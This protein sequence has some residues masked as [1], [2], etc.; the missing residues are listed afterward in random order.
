MNFGQAC[1][2]LKRSWRAYK[3][4]GRDGAGTRADLAWRINR[5]QS[6]MGLKSNFPE[7]EGMEESEEDQELTDELQKEEHEENGVR[8]NTNFGTSQEE[9]ELRMVERGQRVVEGN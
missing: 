1:S 7:L 9:S 5:L 2:A 4:A 8:W 6:S 3:L